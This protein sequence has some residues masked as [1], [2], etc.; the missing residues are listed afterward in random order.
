M[1]LLSFYCSQFNYYMYQDYV[2]YS[3]YSSSMPGTVPSPPAASDDPHAPMTPVSQLGS[4]YGCLP[5]A[6]VFFYRQHPC[7]LSHTI[8]SGRFA[9]P[10][11]CTSVS[12]VTSASSDSYASSKAFTS[13]QVI[14]ALVPHCLALRYRS[15]SI[16]RS[17]T[18]IRPT[19]KPMDSSTT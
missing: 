19:S 6:V 18:A 16:A 3:D 11:G 17:R 1:Q 5:P 7:H 13:Q 15:P 2:G 8:S 4:P 9:P 12:L 14:G 10:H